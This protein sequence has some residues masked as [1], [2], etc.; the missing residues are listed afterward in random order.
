LSSI[1]TKKVDAVSGVAEDERENDEVRRI[2]NW[3]REELERAGYEREYA[4][5]L[6]TAVE[7]DLRDA[8]R[9][10]DAGCRQSVAVLILL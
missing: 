1:W 7:V 9:L 2:L 6:A 8:V 4:D 3:R 5:I 10:L